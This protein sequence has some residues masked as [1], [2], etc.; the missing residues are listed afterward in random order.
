MK[1][2][3]RLPLLVIFFIC[4]LQ[5]C[6]D[7]NIADVD[8]SG[9]ERTYLVYSFP[10]NTQEN[11][12]DK[13]NVIL[14][15]THAIEDTNLQNHVKVY[16]M[17]TDVDN[18]LISGL[19]T[20]HED[21]PETLMFMPNA[22]FQAGQ[23]YRIDYTGITTEFGAV[24]DVRNI[25]FTILPDRDL[26]GEEGSAIFEVVSE[27][28]AAELPFMDFSSIRLTFS[29]E[30]ERNSFVVDESFSLKEEGSDT[31]IA[32]DIFIKGRTLTF[33]PKEDL[34]PGTDYILSL[35]DGI[36]SAS[37]LSLNTAGYE[38]KMYSPQSSL[39]RTTLVQKITDSNDGQILSPLSVGAINSIPLKSIL[40]GEDDTTYVAGDLFAELAF[41]PNYPDAS[42]L[43]LRKGTVMRGSAIEVKIGGHVPAGFNT[44]S[45]NLTLVADSHGYLIKNTSTDDKNAPMQVHLLLDV[46]MTAEDG[47]A[48]G[49]MSQDILHL[50]LFGWAKTED[51][52]LVIDAMGEVEPRILGL[53]DASATVSFH[54][55]AYADQNNP[56]EIP[57]DDI[58]PELQ[59]W[60]PDTNVAYMSLSEPLIIT[61]SEPLANSSLNDA[62]SLM[63][64]GI[65]QEISVYQDGSTLIIQPKDILVDNTL[66]QLL[67]SETI[68][69]ISGNAITPLNLTFTTPFINTTDTAAPLIES[70]YP[71]YN[72]LLK[73]TDIANGI[74]GQCNN[75]KRGDDEF[76]LFEIPANRSI[77]ITFNQAMDID[78]MVLGNECDSGTVRIEQ[79]DINGNCIKSVPGLLKRDATALSFTP[80][81]MWQS[82]ILYRYTLV[83]TVSNDG[84]SDNTILCSQENL[85]LNTDPLKLTSEHRQEGG[86]TFSIVFSAV[87]AENN[88]VFNLL[89]QIPTTD[90]NKNFD[91]DNDE[92]AIVENS[93]I[94]TIDSVSG[95]ISEAK[96]GCRDAGEPCDDKKKIYISGLLPT[97][98]GR[99]DELNQ[100]IEVKIYP[101]VLMASSATIYAKLPFPILWIEEPTGPQIMRVRYEVDGQGNM[102]RPKGYITEN[103]QGQA[104]FSTE[105]N[106]Y[107]DAP[108]LKPLGIGTTNLHSLPLILNLIGPVTFLAD[109]RMEVQ[110]SN[111]DPINI[112]VDI[113]IFGVGAAGILIF[114]K[115]GDLSLNL[116]SR[117]IK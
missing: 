94:L 16:H 115:D 37:G 33:D 8:F 15:F 97:D 24:E 10:F 35:T 26:T 62:I 89:A 23:Q 30:L 103:A 112:D 32:G 31:S 82:D 46:A 65:A 116:V 114:I 49:T 72:C 68:T 53:E 44:G 111:I 85:S 20:Q 105:L 36:Q 101:Q 55:E 117:L 29:H 39:P 59:S 1:L 54:L 109:G 38:G 4:I 81:E 107:F 100:R 17:N 80:N 34:I 52:V 19:V 60:V 67:L 99:W 63:T 48:N 96:I 12:S 57:I 9:W 28:P 69:D 84:C 98:I 76:S 50:E 25:Q 56:P 113:D 104:T 93:G 79:I 22:I 40:I 74:A 70:V 13:T 78:S 73:N 91:F 51:S 45:I 87:A 71:G 11:V 108:G 77:E 110:L 41:I 88:Y 5:G 2:F 66:Y 3:K 86:E 7:E 43:V 18:E 75:G 6:S 27:H 58:S 61:F 92:T 21:A 47:V 42:P 90:T 106:V 83:S 102:I 64:N 14:S 95:L